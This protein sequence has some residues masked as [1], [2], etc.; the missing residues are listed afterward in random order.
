MKNATKYDILPLTVVFPE[1]RVIFDDSPIKID[2]QAFFN[3][4]IWAIVAKKQH[5]KLPDATY[6]KTEDIQS[7]ISIWGRY[8][9]FET[10]PSER[11]KSKIYEYRVKK[12]IFEQKMG[13]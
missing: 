3:F 9:P 12:Q 4:G 13:Q 5:A 2:F 11:K 10:G 8:N 6:R 7:Y 1:T